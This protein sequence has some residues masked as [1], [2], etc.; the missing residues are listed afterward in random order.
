MKFSLLP[1]NLTGFSRSCIIRTISLFMV[2]LLGFIPCGSI[3]DM[4]QPSEAR[5]WVQAD[6]PAGWSVSVDTNETAKPDDVTIRATSPDMNSELTYILAHS[7]DPIT[8]NE[9]QQFQNGY[10]NKL[11]FRICKTKDPIREENQDHTAYR[12][13]YVRGSDDAAVI[14]TISYPGWGVGHYILVMEG[15]DA[16]KQYYESIPPQVIGHLRPSNQNQTA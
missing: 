14:G 13:T 4:W 5:S 16:V 15:P 8:I 7:P 9:I 1:I 2:I 12:Q 10:M 11:G 6:T 3:A